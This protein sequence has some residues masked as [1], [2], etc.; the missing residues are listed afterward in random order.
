LERAGAATLINQG[1]SVGDRIVLIKFG[2]GYQIVFDKTLTQPADK[3]ALLDQIPGAPEPGR[4]TN[5]RW[6]HDAALHI[7]QKSLP[8]PGVIVLLTDSFNDRPLL[9]DPNYPDYLGYYT[10]KGLTVY[11]HTAQNRDYERLLRTLAVPHRIQQYG[12]GVGI[13]PNGRPI[14]RLPQAGQGDDAVAGEG[15]QTTVAQQAVGKEQVH[16][17]LLPWILGTLL[18]L[19]ALFWL[20]WSRLNRPVP[21]RLK[22]GDRGTP[23]DYRLRP[24]AKVG[25]G[26]TPIMA[27]PGDD[28]FPLAGL[29]APAAFAQAQR[30][31]AAVI[32]P[33]AIDAVKVLHNGLPLERAVPLRIGDEVRL[34]VPAT[35][36]EP[37]RE[38]RVHMEDPRG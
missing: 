13:A 29:P 20:F 28:V 1:C 5:I 21:L 18:L 15:A 11:P 8:H 10:L 9:T 37:V 16:R 27:A 30:G 23:R 38:H 4:G 26:G 19:L 25:L 32:V 2:T 14:E 12:I 31:G 17:S 7:V 3:D 6:P 33:S 34:V 36:T 35:D 24:G 22:L